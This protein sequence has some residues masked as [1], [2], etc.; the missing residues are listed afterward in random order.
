MEGEFLGESGAEGAAELV[1]FIDKRCD[2]GLRAE[3]LFLFLV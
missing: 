3:D 1:E 2:D